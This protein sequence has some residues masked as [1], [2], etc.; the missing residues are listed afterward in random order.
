M[1]ENAG[2]RPQKEETT[3][4]SSTLAMP[5]AFLIHGTSTKDDDW[6]PWIEK[7]A[8]KATPAIDVTRLSL[9]TPFTPHPQQW[10]DAI[11]EQIPVDHDIVLIAH[12][13]GCIAALRWIERHEDAHNIGLVLVGAFDKPLPAYK[14]LDPFVMPPLDYSKVKNKVTE[15]VV[16]TAKDDPIAPMRGSLS[17][18]EHLGAQAVL[19]ANGGHFLASN[20]FTKFPAAL[21]ELTQTATA[22]ARVAAGLPL[23][24]ETSS[25]T[26]K[27]AAQTSET[28]A[29]TSDTSDNS[30]SADTPASA[31]TSTPVASA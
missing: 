6:F 18:P 8:A 10:A 20:G 4:Q 13:L 29:Q 23:T 16:I 24:A 1:S 12:S 26:T 11:D 27:T 30:D 17:V 7:A 21:S 25:Q 28:A 31:D 5:P 15:P 9:P 19:C 14:V 2:N 22:V 3:Q